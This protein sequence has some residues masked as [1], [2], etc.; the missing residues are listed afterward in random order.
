MIQNSATEILITCTLSEWKE[1]LH[2]FHIREGIDAATRALSNV[3]DY[4]RRLDRVG[5]NKTDSS[6]GHIIAQNGIGMFDAFYSLEWARK[7]LKYQK[8][9]A[10]M[11]IYYP[12]CLF[13]G[14]KYKPDLPAK[15][16]MKQRLLNEIQDLRA[17][18]T[19]ANRRIN[20]LTAQRARSA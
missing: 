1:Y 19:E 20:E 10:R 14:L 18:L 3:C 4:A 11:D 9:L 17:S 16:T 5:F 6:Q 13:E 7:L 15:I 12:M 8:Q 2:L